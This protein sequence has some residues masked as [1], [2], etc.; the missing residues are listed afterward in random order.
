MKASSDSVKVL[1][2]ESLTCML[3][4]NLRVW[5]SKM[6]GS[7]VMSPAAMIIARLSDVFGR[8]WAVTTS[9]VSTITQDASRR[10]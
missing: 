3:I 8:R 4:L 6:N 2:S 10:W 9:F 1:P 7:R 5:R